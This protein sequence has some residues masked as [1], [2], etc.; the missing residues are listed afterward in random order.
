MPD[1]KELYFLLFAASA[2]AVDAMEQLNFGQA[3][4]ILIRV[5]QKAEEQCIRDED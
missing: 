5:Q 2:D 4:D 1:Y 3:K